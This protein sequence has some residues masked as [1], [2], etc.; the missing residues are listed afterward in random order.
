M[1][2]LLEKLV[3]IEREITDEKGLCSLFA[4]LLREDVYGQWDLLVSAPYLHAD[5]LQ[6]LDYI[7]NK[8]YARLDIRELVSLTGVII[9]ETGNPVV[10]A[11]HEAIQ[12]QHGLEELR[13]RV[14]ASVESQHVY[15]IT[16]ASEPAPESGTLPQSTRHRRR[17]PVKPARA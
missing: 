10:E 1:K 17:A 3:A 15:V 8:L 16:S 12:V 2:K 11:I 9:L 7:V 13:D 4:L 14:F 5:N 6:S